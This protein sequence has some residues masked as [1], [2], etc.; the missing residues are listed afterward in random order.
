MAPGSDG[1]A[2]V[3]SARGLV[4]EYRRGDV[5]VR[6][7]DGV[8]L[9]V[10][11][12]T[13]LAIV[14]PSGSGKST[15]LHLLSALDRPTSG[16]VAIAGRRLSE[17][18]D[19]ELSDLRRDEVGF[20]F[21]FFNLLPTLSAWE[22]V[23]LPATFGGARLGGLRAR[24]VE[25]LDRV[26]MADRVEHRPA[27]L[28]GGQ[29]QRV[30]IARALVA[31]PSLVVADEPTGNLD[32]AAGAQVLDLL[33][34]LVNEGTT[35]VM[36]THSEEA[37]ARADRV[38]QLRDGRIAGEE[39]GRAPVGGSG[40]VAHRLDVTVSAQPRPHAGGGGDPRAGMS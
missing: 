21:Q 19:D 31:G 10:E 40:A 3:V 24:A 23:A 8:D 2:P 17:R 12:G 20:V 15:L 9:D 28:S 1:V 27:E 26:G 30:A 7:L 11:A 39:T 18:S 6:A 37:A 29:L 38:V 22:N 34:G 5:V 4:K 16:E 14:G 25:L 33:S 35:L 36:V 13:F 32:S